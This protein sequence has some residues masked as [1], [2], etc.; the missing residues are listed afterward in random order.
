VLIPL[1]ENPLGA[2]DAIGA[3]HR[4]SLVTPPAGASVSVH[5]LVQAVIPDQ[6]PSELAAKWRQA[7]ALIEAAIA[8]D[9]ALP[10][11]WLVGAALLP[12]YAGGHLR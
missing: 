4:Y 12:P 1:M 3:F 5:R 6:M 2:D 10:G 8:D 7:A 9:T 11:T